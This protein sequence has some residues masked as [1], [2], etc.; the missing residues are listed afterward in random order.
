LGGDPVN[1]SHFLQ[2]AKQTSNNLIKGGYVTIVDDDGKIILDRKLL[3]EATLLESG[4]LEK[5]G[6]K[7]SEKDESAVTEERKRQL[8]IFRNSSAKLSKISKGS[9]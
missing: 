9:Q 1:I 3:Q 6:S 5:R 4:Y 2:G 7:R 8:G